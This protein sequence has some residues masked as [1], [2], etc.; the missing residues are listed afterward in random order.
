MN[1]FNMKWKEN[2][3]KNNCHEMATQGRTSSVWRRRAAAKRAPLPSRSC[4]RSCRSHSRCLPLC[5]LPRG[6]YTQPLG[7]LFLPI[8]DG[9]WHCLLHVGFEMDTMYLSE[10]CETDALTMLC[11]ELAIQIS[12]QFEAL[13]SIIRAKSVVIVGGVDIMEQSIALAKKVWHCFKVASILV[14]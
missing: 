9:T 14:N 5:F 6:A 8:A 3:I 12:E 2:K 1:E 13:G 11:R 7:L 10:S 4:K